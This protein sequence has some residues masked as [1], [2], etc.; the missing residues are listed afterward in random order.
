MKTKPGLFLG[1]AVLA[2]TAIF[3]LAG[4]DNLSHPSRL[5]A[6]TPAAPT[7]VTAEALSSSSIMVSWNSVSGAIGYTV[8]R[9]T[10]SG[11]SYDYCG[12]VYGASTTSYT[13]TGL[14]PE[15]TYY[16]KVAAENSYREGPLSSY[17]SAETSTSG[18]PATP[19]NVTAQAQSSSSISVSWDSVPD[20]IGYYVYRAYGS[21]GS[22]S[23]IASTTDTSYM[24]S[25][26]SSNTTYYYRVSAHNDNGESPRSSYGYA[27]T[28][29]SNNT[30]AAPS[31]V[32]AQAQSSSSISISW[33]SVYNVLGYRVYRS[34]GAYDTYS[35]I[36]NNLSTTFYADE[37]LPA[38]TTYYYK[39]SA[40]NSGG[41]GWQSSY[42]SATTH[43]GEPAGLADGVWHDGNMTA[44]GSQYY[45]FPVALGTSYEVYWN[46][47]N[48]GD[49]T[50][51]LD[52]KVSAYYE[53][54]EVSIFSGE[55]RGYNAPQTF[56]AT[57]SGNVIIRVEPWYS[58]SAGTYAVKYQ[59]LAPSYS[60]SG[61]I[62]TDNPG[63]PAS[64]ASVQLKRDGNNVGSASTDA[65]GA[66]AIPDVPAETGYTIEVSLDGYLPETSASFDVSGNV[67]DK[68]LTLV[69]IVTVETVAISSASSSVEKGG[70]QNFYAA[71]TGTGDPAQTVNWR[72]EGNFSGGTTIDNAGVLSVDANET[73]PSL[74]VIATSTVDLTKSG[75]AIVTVTMSPTEAAAENFKASHS[76]I[77]TKP[78]EDITLADEDAVDDA[79]DAY[80][81][82]P[83]AAKDLLGPEKSHLDSLKAKIEDLKNGEATITLVYPTD[84]ADTALTY[85]SIA[86]YKTGGPPTHILTVSG[87]FD[88]YQWRV[89]GSARGNGKIFTLRAEDYP[90]GIHQISLEVTLN[91]GVY[92]KSGVFTVQ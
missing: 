37:D 8:Y 59:S 74:T 31:N 26:L 83:Q 6:A 84:A 24:D 91:G 32:T 67:A 66:Y 20:I 22:Y 87:D 42:T 41:E 50:K 71:V 73:A 5:G 14:S 15:T 55:D 92:S 82:L 25:D 3:A 61:T 45:R 56:T 38:S 53:T 58:G 33:D 12:W 10:G 54:G 44:S 7:G 29:S 60:V 27:K 89:D 34:T 43:A 90:T 80:D 2:L 57:S 69:R 16:Y 39:V 63:G 23:Q 88:S 46:D 75:E 51:T 65:N 81:S 9:A 49:Y 40:Y 86:I 76:D 47:S 18:V 17:A 1:A 85:G 19:A 52:I 36:A 4:C 78:V 28:E 30:L 48:Q 68:N 70:T 35:V 79:R 62:D 72:V 64:N 77:L 13:D 11:G 21:D